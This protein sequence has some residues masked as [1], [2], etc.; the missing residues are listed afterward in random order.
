MNGEDEG[1]LPK[2][3]GSPVAASK[4]AANK[5]RFTASSAKEAVRKRGKAGSGRGIAREARKHSKW[6]VKELRAMAEASTS[7]TARQKAMELLLRYAYGSAPSAAEMG[8]IDPVE[9]TSDVAGGAPY[10]RN[11]RGLVVLPPPTD[12]ELL[13]RLQEIAKRGADENRHLDAIGLA[14]LNPEERAQ[15]EIL[16]SKMRSEELPAPPASQ[17]APVAPPVST[18]MARVFVLVP[19]HRPERD[20]WDAPADEDHDR[21]RG[22]R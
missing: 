7:E 17:E 9:G 1:T 18:P 13:A 10:G 21:H 8:A 11:P 12:G 14:R 6:V 4:P 5:G 20:D 22:D 2:A 19:P 3:P 15:L 16:Q